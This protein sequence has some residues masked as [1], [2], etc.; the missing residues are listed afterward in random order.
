MKYNKIFPIFLTAVSILFS[1][2]VTAGTTQN[3]TSQTQKFISQTQKFISQ[4]PISQKPISPKPS[5]SLLRVSIVNDGTELKIQDG[6]TTQTIKAS[7]L[8]LRLIN[9]LNCQAKKVLPTQR[10]SGKRFIPQGF[11]FNPTNGNLAVGVVLQECFDTQQSAVFVLEPQD[12]WSGY[13]IY[14]VQLPGT[15]KLPDEFSSYPF[16]TI[17]KIGF[18]G[19]DLL[20]KHGDASGTEALVVFE[21]SGKPAGKYDGCLVTSA[22]ESQNICPIVIPD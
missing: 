21:N 14:R 8:N 12:N 3:N 10:L 17:Q 16:R 15:K 4:Q 22:G 5:K 6:T 19:D 13:A 9:G 18:F 11:S 20:V 1:V 2:S 7:R